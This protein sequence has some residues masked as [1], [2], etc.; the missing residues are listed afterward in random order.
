M[1]RQKISVSVYLELLSLFSLNF[2]D[3]SAF[4]NPFLQGLY[5]E[6]K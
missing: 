3:F 5:K 2:Y 6:K 4:F 1:Y